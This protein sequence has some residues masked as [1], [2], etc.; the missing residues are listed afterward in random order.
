MSSLEGRPLA[1]INGLR[2]R[3]RHRLFGGLVV[4]VSAWL[5]SAPAV[6]YIN[7]ELRTAN[8]W[9]PGDTVRVGLYAV[10]DTPDAQSFD[11][12]QALCF[13]D[14]AFLT[15]LGTD[16]TGAAPWQ[17]AGFTPSDPFGFN[18]SNPPQDGDGLWS[19]NCPTSEPILATAQGTLLT[20]FEFQALANTGGTSVNLVLTA[21]KPDHYPAYTR[22]ISIGADVLGTLAVASVM[23]I[24]HP[25]GET[26]A[27]ALVITS[28]PFRTEG[29]TCN[30]DDDYDE[31]CEKLLPSTP[32]PTTQP[33]G[34]SPDIVY[35]FTPSRG[36]MA[37][38]IS[39][40]RNSAYD[41]KLYVYEDA[42]GA[43]Q[44]GTAI[45]CSDDA[46][47]TPSS[48]SAVVS[49]I[50]ALNLVAGHTYYFVVDGHGGACG[51]YTIDVYASIPG[52]NCP[53]DTGYCLPAHRPDSAWN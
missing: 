30:A 53:E 25:P 21:T 19:A 4:L 52:P 43:Y 48:P 32:R 3:T 18:E 16:Q 37:I 34:G 29:N 20:T 15:L 49:E 50:R 46:C 23:L 44:S 9:H 27:G 47:S 31:T 24:S 1:A 41:T 6:A 42:C 11:A 39:L 8:P 14:P 35:Q 36:P 17:S 38:D 26:C 13:W 45:A 5:L 28:L 10:S 33:S 51:N 7:L 22:A 40:C 12:V 2:A